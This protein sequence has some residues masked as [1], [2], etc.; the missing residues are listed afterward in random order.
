MLNFALFWCIDI[1]S[2]IKKCVLGSNLIPE[3]Q[4]KCMS[5]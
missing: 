4:K 3:K 5:M 1:L 2:V